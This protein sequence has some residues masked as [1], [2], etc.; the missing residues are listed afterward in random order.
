MALE[1]KG[2][3]G[4][5]RGNRKGDEGR[6]KVRFTQLSTQRKTRG[7]WGLGSGASHYN[8]QNSVGSRK[9]VGE[10]SAGRIYLGAETN[11]NASPKGARKELT[12][13]SS[14]ERGRKKPQGGD[15]KTTIYGK[16]KGGY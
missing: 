14:T 13:G 10:H 1:K 12:G 15:Q 4:G 7:S 2:R 5:K 3:Q 16:E 8:G 11:A 6:A 9:S